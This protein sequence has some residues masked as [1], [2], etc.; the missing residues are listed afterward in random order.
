MDCL[1]RVGLAD[2]A[3][4]RV[5][6]LSGGQSQRVAVARMLMQQPTLVIADEPDASLDPKSGEEVMAM[7]AELAGERKATLIFVSHR[8]EHARQFSDAS[9]G[10][11][12]PCSL[13]RHSS[14]V[15]E[16][17]LFQ[18]LQAGS[19]GMTN[20]ARGAC[21][22]SPRIERLNP[23]GVTLSVAA[24]AFVLWSLSAPALP[25]TSS[26]AGLPNIGNIVSRMIPPD[27]SR[28]DRILAALFQTFQMAVAGC[29]IGL[30]LSVPLGILAADGL[31]PH[32]MIRS[33]HGR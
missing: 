12:A 15:S 16:A 8:M 14:G 1:D 33:A 23:I 17:E 26:R 3:L 2:K 21:C 24:A 18:F 13:D 19:G 5:D 32:P 27:L 11:V 9:L 6:T 7:L 20:P 10:L 4:S 30:V 22:C 25:S 28:L 29:V 31:S